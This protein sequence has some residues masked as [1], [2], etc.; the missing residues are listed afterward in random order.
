[1]LPR[2]GSSL[3]SGSA[4]KSGIS[5][6]LNGSSA[7]GN[8]SF[9]DRLSARSRVTNLGILILLSFASLSALFNLRYMLFG[10]I[11]KSNP[12]PPGYSSWATFHGYTP[13]SLSKSVPPPRNGTESLNHLVLVVGHAIWAG[14]DVKGRENDENWILEEY[15][16]GGSVKSFYKHIEKGVQIASKDPEALLVFSGGQTRNQSL[17]T[18]AESYFSLAVSSGLELPIIQG[19]LHEGDLQTSLGDSK[20]KTQV[21]EL[22]HA[23]AAVATAHGLQ[24]VR[25]T[26]ENFALDSFEN[27][28]FSI[29][30]FREYTG[31]YPE[32]IT[33]VGYAFKKARFEELHA[34]AI[35]WPTRT[36]IAGG[37]RAFSY[38]GID[39]EGEDNSLA[40]QGERLKGYSLF[41]KDMYGCHGK[42]KDKR[43]ERNPTRRFHPYF[44]SAPEL[45]DLLNWCPP[46]DSGLQGVYPMNLP[47][48]LRVTG[49]GWGRGAQAL[50]AKQSK[51]KKLPDIRWLTFGRE[52]N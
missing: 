13:D 35:R 11:S 7:N 4:R 48:D 15:Q 45:A 28:L 20:A 46:K 43:I 51:G 23:N 10:T 9:H 29:A 22:A 21:G 47:W 19:S 18:E 40:Y 17:Q 41:E 1:M 27:L 5:L 25:M 2:P 6:A 3:L 38:V 37:Q 31:F 49:S 34:K 16:K 24:D 52:R 12:P 14:C 30:R 42:L 32:R 8:V 36:Y 33:V 26:T 50:R 44:S 39:D